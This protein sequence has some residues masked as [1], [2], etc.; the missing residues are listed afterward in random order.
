MVL[1]TCILL[2]CFITGTLHKMSPRIRFFDEFK[3][4]IRV[5]FYAV[6]IF[7]NFFEFF[8]HLRLN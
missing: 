1:Y 5:D 7:L 8:G 2:C 6:K 3:W 4:F